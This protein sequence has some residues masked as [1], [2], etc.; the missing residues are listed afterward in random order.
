MS[1]PFRTY[2]YPADDRD[3]WTVE[4][5]LTEGTLIRRL[6]AFAIDGVIVVMLLKLLS[7][8]LFIFGILTLG[9][10][11]SLYALLPL[12]APLYNWLSLLSPLCAT[13]G[14]ALLGLV[15]C[16]NDDLGPPGAVAALVWVIGFYVSLACS[17]VPLLLALLTQRRRTLHDIVSGLVVVRAGA[18][19]RA[20]GSWNMVD[21]GPRPYER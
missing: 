16:R 4:M 20:V 12:V 8:A 19:T 21:G 2:G 11:F 3:V 14:Q 6:I 9:L 13:P 1:Q 18:L 7:I 17:G 5:L 10:G 15:V